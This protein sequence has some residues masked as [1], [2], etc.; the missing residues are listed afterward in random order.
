MP[1]DKKEKKSDNEKRTT[2]LKSV[3]E[4]QTAKKSIPSKL[5]KFQWKMRQ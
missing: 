2:K 5:L 4:T 1:K 3:L